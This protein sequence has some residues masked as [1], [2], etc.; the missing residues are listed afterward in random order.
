MNKQEDEIRRLQRLR[1]EQLQARDPTA[2]ERARQQR[3]VTKH[4]HTRKKITAKSVFLDLPAKWQY[5][6]IGT[7]IGLLVALVINIVVQAQWAQIVGGGL[8]VFGLVAGR[9]M[10]AIRD[11]GNEDWG[12]KY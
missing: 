9:V 4:R 7:L 5:M 12:R 8:V 3:L 1:D 11:W 6:L 2:K 10:G